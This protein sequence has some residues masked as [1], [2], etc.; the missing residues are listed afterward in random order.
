MD[1]E[2]TTEPPSIKLS[3]LKGFPAPGN[4]IRKIPSVNCESG[5]EP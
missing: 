2:T 1:L 3:D 4:G 5:K